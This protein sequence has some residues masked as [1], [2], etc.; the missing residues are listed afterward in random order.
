VRWAGVDW[1]VT[2]RKE[3]EQRLRQSEER[4]RRANS[5][6]GI[7]LYEWNTRTGKAHWSPEAYEL[8]GCEQKTPVNYALWF[9]SLHP[10]DRDGATQKVAQAIECAQQSPAAVRYQDQ[11]RVLRPNGMI[12]W[13]SSTGAFEHQGEDLVM[14]GAVRDITERKQTEAILE[15]QRS[16]LRAALDAA[17]MGAWQ[18]HLADHRCYYSE[19]AQQLYGI[20]APCILHDETGAREL[21]HEHDLPIMWQEVEKACD[22]AGDG[23]YEVEYRVRRADGGW[24]WLRVWGLAEFEGE[25][26]GRKAVRI[27]GASRD[28]TESRQAKEELL[29]R[30]SFYRQTLESIPGMVFTTRPDG[31]CDYQSQ[32]WVEYTGIPMSEHVGDGWNKLLHPED[33]PRAFAAWRSAVEGGAAYDLEYRVR[34]HDH[35]YEWFK[36]IGRPIRDSGGRIVRWFGVAINIEALKRAERKLQEQLELT[37]TIT[38]N[39]TQGIFMMD[40]NGF[41]T[42]VNP[43]A[44]KMFGFEWEEIC[45]RPL[46]ELI[47]HH[48]P[49]GRPYPMSECPIDRALPENFDVR[50]HEDVFIRKNGEFFP[51]LVAVSPIFKEGKPVSTVIEVRD[52]GERKLA[53][54]KLSQ[55]QEKLQK[56]AATLEK[57]VAE[58]T[59]RL[60]ET[61]AELEHFSYTITHDMRA[62][63]RA[64]QSFAEILRDDHASSFDESAAD[65]LRRIRQAAGRM[66]SLITTSLN[67]AKAMQKELELESLDPGKLLLGMVE[68]Y[69]QFQPPRAQIHIAEDLPL[70][71]ANQAGLTQCFSNLL[72]NAVK[73]V[74]PGV[75]PIVKIWGEEHG[76]F[77]RLWVQDNGIGIPSDQQEHVFELFQR[78]SQS[79][80]GTGVGLALV[81][82]V[83][84]KMR[85]KVGLMPRPGPGSLFWVELQKG[86]F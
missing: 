7:G 48:H 33:Q 21:I 5:A 55:A 43:A 14:V 25:G 57:T 74:E 11:F 40:P 13:L 51:V 4:L 70:V 50:E 75:V 80:E 12:A 41:C 34:R 17:S 42:F 22:P 60:R 65:Y 46:H 15:Q 39:A 77:V 63:L 20:S 24:R 58:R 53:E 76:E 59:D 67:Y 45:A 38:D 71:L 19:E 2:E 36:V 28:I 52:I 9:N 16:A 6:G 66:D 62:P 73:F 30:E 49:D 56:H 26:A 8:F 84:G 79:H 81:R 61:V 68:S 10:E 72:G 37:R 85:G 29:E 32:Q 1:D 54:Q 27:H 18:Y 64:M 78:L 47:H 86:G 23:R 83:V 82:K 44:K 69:P 3:A 31:Y 35:S